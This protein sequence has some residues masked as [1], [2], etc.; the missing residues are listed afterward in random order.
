MTGKELW[1]KVNF[2]NDGKIA[3]ILFNLRN[4]WQCEKEYEDINDY[5]AIIQKS[6]PEAYKISKRP[7]SI[8]CKCDDCD[9]VIKIVVSGNYL[10]CVGSIINKAH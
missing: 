7:F 10:K 6:I 2:E 3:D 1:H 9:I 5:L 8:T 4:R